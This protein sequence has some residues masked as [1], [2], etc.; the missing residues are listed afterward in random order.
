M[1]EDA[2][3]PTRVGIADRVDLGLVASVKLFYDPTIEEP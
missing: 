2:E 3:R 1:D